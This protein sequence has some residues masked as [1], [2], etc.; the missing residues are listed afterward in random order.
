MDG[1]ACTVS[2]NVCFA[3]HTKRLGACAIGQIAGFRFRNKHEN[4]N[5]LNV[6]NGKMVGRFFQAVNDSF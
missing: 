4:T 6:A 1:R 2:P 5:E 3:Q